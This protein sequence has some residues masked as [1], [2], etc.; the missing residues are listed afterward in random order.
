MQFSPQ[1]FYSTNNFELT[2][3]SK[4]TR[5]WLAALFNF[6]IRGIVM[7]CAYFCSKLYT[8]REKRHV[9][10]DYC[11]CSVAAYKYVL[12]GFFHATSKR[13][14]QPRGDIHTFVLQTRNYSGTSF[15]VFHTKYTRILFRPLFLFFF[16]FLPPNVIHI[17]KNTKRILND[18]EQIHGFSSFGG[19]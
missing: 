5:I 4:A 13:I 11:D 16:F 6:P 8:V 1:N 10:W 19:D 15:S 12:Y 9:H 2:K 3:I 7:T 14:S 17:V 18:K